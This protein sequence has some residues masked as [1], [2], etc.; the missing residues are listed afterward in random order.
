[1]D[2]DGY[3]IFRGAISMPP[4]NLISDNQVDYTE[5]TKFIKDEMLMYVNEKFNWKCD[6]IK[7]RVSDNNNSADASVF[8]RDI[9]MQHSNLIPVFTCLTYMDETT[10]EIIP[11]SHKAFKLKKRKITMY[12]GDLMVFYSTLMHRG[13]FTE[14]LPH[15]RLIQVFEVCRTPQELDYFLKHSVHVPADEMY[16]DFMIWVSKT[17]ILNFIPNTLSYLNS[18]FGYGNMGYENIEFFSS[19]GLRG[20]LPVGSHEINKYV[21]NHPTIDIPE[22]DRLKFK[23][24]CYWRQYIFCTLIIVWIIYII[25]S[26]ALKRHKHR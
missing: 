22:S 24:V 23:F 20:R 26:Q 17:P 8:H 12:P 21:L 25:M 15:R 18:S 9:I 3:I 5:M 2:D 13:I 16:S 4:Y 14:N 1:M 10:M 11:G 19:E 6:Y 7:Y